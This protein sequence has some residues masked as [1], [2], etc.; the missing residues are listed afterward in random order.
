MSAT[1]LP[2]RTSA[3]QLLLPALLACYLVWGST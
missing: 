1:A 2:T 3:A